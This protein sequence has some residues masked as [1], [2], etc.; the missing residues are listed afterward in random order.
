MSGDAYI[1][2]NLGCSDLFANTLNGGSINTYTA[3]ANI[4]TF[5]IEHP[6]KEK[7]EEHYRLRHWVIE[8]D[9]IGGSCFYRRKINC[10]VGENYI[11]MPD[12]FEFLVT[13]VL[14]FTSSFDHFGQSYGK[15]DENDKNKIIINCNQDGDYNILITG[16][17]NDES[18]TCDKCPKE[19]EYIR[20]PV[21]QEHH[22]ECCCVPNPE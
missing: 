21:A 1:S 7:A 5:D 16:C 13:D 10:Q 2:T 3:S 22:E 9:D 17:R 14:I 4:K 20:E 19:V 15:Q 11:M 6:V 8:T 12:W 18:V